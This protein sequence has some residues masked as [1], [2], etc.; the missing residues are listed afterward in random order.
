MLLFLIPTASS[1]VL[2][3]LAYYLFATSTK[4]DIEE[5]KGPPSALI[6]DPS[7]YR[8]TGAG[9]LDTAHLVTLTGAVYAFALALADNSMT[10]IYGWKTWHHVRVAFKRTNN[11]KAKA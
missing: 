4:G 8:L 6:P 1:A 5:A 10:V 2:A 3:A 11:A 9:L 7:S